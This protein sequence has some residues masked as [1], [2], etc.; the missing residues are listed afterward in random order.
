[1]FDNKKLIGSSRLFANFIFAGSV[2]LLP[3]TNAFAAPTIGLSTSFLPADGAR[4]YMDIGGTWDGTQE[5]SNGDGFTLSVA[6]TG[7]DPAFD[8]RDIPVTVPTG[9]VLASN[10]VTVTD[11]G[12][13]CP[14]M[15]ANASQAGSGNPVTINIFSNN[16]TVINP[17]CTYNYTFRLETNTTAPAGTQSIGYTVTYNTINN[18]NSSVASTLGTQNINVNAGGISVT[19]STAITSAVTGQVISYNLTV[20]STGNG[21]LFDVEL[22]DVLSSDLNNLTFNVPNPPPGANGPGADDYTFEYLSA[23]EI[24]NLTVDATVSP[25]L[26]CPL[27][28][29]TANMSER[30]GIATDSAGPVNV[31]YDFQFTSGSFSNVLSHAAT[32]YCEFC[33]DGT[34]T[35]T[36]QN[37]SNAPLTNVSLL[38]D[39]KASGLVYITG[40][41]TFNGGGVADP[42]IT[43]GSNQ[44]LTWALP[45]IAGSGSVVVS[46]GVR[47]ANAEALNTAVRDIIATVD[48]DMSCLTATQSVNSGDFEVPIRQPLPNIFKDGRNFDAGQSG[49]TD[50]IFGSFNDDIIWRVNVQNAGLANMQAL[51]MNDATNGPP[52]DNF[53]INYICPTEANAVAITNNNGVDPGTSCIAMG[54]PF[55]VADPFG[56]APD[57]DDIALSSNNAFIYYV[58]RIKNL[59]TTITNTA[60]ISWGCAVNS[61][62][63]GNIT[64]PASSNGITPGVGI[65]ETGILN[66][67]VS[68]PGLQ[69]TQTVT[70]SNASQPLGAKGLIT[71]TLNNQTD[72]SIQKITVD[73]DLP[74]GYVMDESYGVVN[75]VGIGQPT[76]V[77]NPAYGTTYPGF[78]DTFTRDDPQLNN[79]DPLDDLNPT[80]TLSSSTT[81][82]NAAQQV[83][84]LRNGDVVSFTFGIIMIDPNAFD[85][86]SDLD[87]APE[88]IAD[89]TDP[90][91]A[92]TNL[93]NNV[94][95]N[96]DSVDPSGLQAQTRNVN[97]TYD[98]D[99]ED[100][101]VS[102]SDALFILTNNPGTPLALNVD[103]TNN[104][105]H[106]ADDYSLY[107]SLGQAMVV[108]TP[109]AGCSLTS[110]APP[111]PTWN[112][113]SAIPGPLTAPVT[114]AAEIYLCNRGTIAPGQTQTFTFDV[115]KQL[116]GTPA[117]DL[118]FRADVVGEVRLFDTTRLTYSGTPASP[119][120]TPPSLPET[121]P[122]Q[123]LANNYTLDAI[124]SRVLGFNLTKSVLACSESAG[125]E[126]QIGEDCSYHIES[127]GWFGF[128]T[129]G[130]TLIAVENVVVTD[131]LPNN[132]GLDGQ[133][134]I[135]FPG[136]TSPYYVFNNTPKI[137]M[138]GNGGATTTPLDA[139]DITWSF[140][141]SGS[142]IV[143]KDEFFRVDLKTRLLNNPVDLAYPVPG[144]YAPNL[145]GNITTNIARTSFDAIFNSASGNVTI[146]VDD[147]VGIPGYPVPAVRTVN[148]TEVEPNLIVTKQV[149]N[150]SLNGSGTAC[151][152]FADAIN[153]GDTNDSYIYRITLT[154]ENSVPVRSPAFNVIATDTLDASDLMFVM[155]FANDNL[156]NNGDGS[157]ANGD[158]DE[159][160]MYAAIPDNTVGNGIP[161]VITVDESFGAPFVQVDPGVTVTFYYRVD[162]DITIAPLQTLTNTVSMSFD[163]LDGDFG[164]QNV[165]QYNNSTAPPNDIG[166]AR[167]YTSIAQI[168]DV[169]M[170]PVI[171][172]PK[173][174]VTT[175][176]TPPSSPQNVSVGEEVRYLLV[177]DLPV[178]NLRQFKIRDEL[179]AGIRCIEGLVVNL[180]AP[181]YKAAGFVPGGTFVSNCT[182]TGTNDFVEWNFGNQIVTAAGGPGTRFNFP[183]SFIARVENSAITTGTTVI[184]NGGGTVNTT[185]PPSASYCTGGVGVCYVNDV[186]TV[187]PHNF[188][189]VDIVVR[190]PVIALTKSFLPVTNSDA[191]DVLTVTVTAENTG[192]SVAYNLQVLDDLVGSDMTYKPGSLGGANPPDNVDLVTLGANQPIFSWD[193]A[194]PDYAIQTGAA[195]LK[196][197]TFQV[198][199]DTTAQPLELLDNTLQSKWDS[200]PDQNTA[201]PHNTA[202]PGI[203]P[204][205]SILGLRNG[206]VP[207]LATAPN[208]YETIAAASTTVPPLTMTKTD[209]VPAVIP[210]IG[211]H[212]N[213]QVVIELPEGTTENLIVDDELVFGGVSYALSR[214]ASFDITYT[215][216]DIVSINGLAPSEAAFRGATAG[217]PTLPVDNDTGTITW[218]IGQIITDEED[219]LDI[220]PN[221]V[222]PRIIINYFAR[223]NNDA[224]TIDGVSIQNSATVN[225]DHG[226]GGAA[227]SINDRTAV[228]TVVEP[229]LAITKAVSNITNLGVGPVAGDVLE[230]QISINN[231]GNSTAF[232]SN[233]TDTLDANLLFDASFTPT[234]LLNTVAVSGFVSTPSGVPGGPLIWGR[235]N[236]DNSLDIPV[237]PG[238]T[239]VLT[240]RVIVQNTIEANFVISNSALVDWTSLNDTDPSNPFERTGA[241]CPL[242]S[243][244]NT[245]CSAPAVADITADNSNNI[246]KTVIDDTWPASPV[247]TLRVGDVVTYQLGVNIQQG[248][249]VSMRIL[250]AIDPGMEFV[251]VVSINGAVAAPYAPPA[252]GAGSNFSYV[253]IPAGDVPA[254]GDAPIFNWDLGTII[255][256]FS[257]DTTTDMLVII[258]RARVV[259]NVA[260]TIPQQPTTQINNTANLTFMD[261]NNSPVSG[262]SGSAFIT[263]LQPVMDNLTKTDRSGRVSGGPITP[264]ID[265][266]N[267]TLHSCNTTGLA[268]A[269]GLLLTD[270]LPTQLNET[271]ITGPTN[272]ALAPDVL[273]NGVLAVAAT[274]YVYTPP[275]GPGG[276]MV[277]R[278]NT[279]IDPGVCIDINFDV[280]FYT[281]FGFGAF[282]ND[283][284]VNEYYSLP[285]ADAQLYGPLGPA[286]FVMNNPLAPIPAPVKVK[287]SADEATIGDEVIYQITVPSVATGAV[288]YDVTTTDVLDSSLILVSAVDTG[289]SNF[290]ITTT[291]LAGNTISMV[292]DQIPAGQTAIIELRARVDNN[293]AANASVNFNNSASYTYANSPG[294]LAINAGSDITVNALSIVEPLVAVVK[295]VTNTTKAGAPDAGDILRYTV[296]LSAS[297]GA[298]APA[299]FF[300]D[301]FD[302]SIDD[303]LSLGLLYIDGSETVNGGNSINLPVKV[304]DG[305][306]TPQTLSWSPANP[307]PSDIDVAEG[308]TV[309]VTY[310]VLVLDSVLANQNLSNSVDIQWS[311]RDG[312]D[313]NERDGSGLPLNDYFN[314]IT[315]ST[316]EITPDNNVITKLKLS[317]TFNPADNIVRI[318]DIVEYELRINMQEGSNP[319]FVVQ[320]NLPRGL[321]FEQTV[322]INGQT[323]APYADVAPF[324]YA[325][326]P[327]AV[328]VGDP[329]TGPT[330]VSWSTADVINA[331]DNITTNNDFVIIYRARVLNLA[332]PQINNTPLNNIVDF[333]YTT[334]SGPAPTKTDNQQLDLQQPD[335][336]VTKTSV[337]AAGSIIGANDFVTY[338]VEIL[339]SGASI[340]YDTELLDTIPFGLRSPAVN[341]ISII[342]QPSGVVLPNL[343]PVYNPATGTASWNF[344]TGT[345]NQYNIPAGQR[346]QI[347]YQMQADAGLGAGLNMTN[348][349]QV[350]LYYSF[351]DDATPSVPPITGVREIYGP[352]NIASVTLSTVLPNALLKVNPAD[353]NI[354]IGETFNYRITIPETPQTTTLYDVQILDDLNLS[355]ADLMF[356][357]ATKVSGSL[358]FT[359]VNIGTVSGELIIADT[360]N[361]IDVPANEQVVID[362]TVTLRDSATN[363]ASLP[364]TNAAS[365]T[366]NQINGD[367]A[368]VSTGLGNTTPLMTIVE[369]DLTMRKDGPV[370]TVNFLA[371][372][373]YTV[374]VENIGTGPAFDTTITDRLPNVPDNPPLTGGTC[375]TTP[376]NFVAGITTS[377]D[378]SIVIRA[379]T[380]GTDYNIAYTAAP[381]CELLITTITDAAR[382]ESNE[383]LIVSYDVTLNVASQSGA[384][385]TNIAGATEWFSLNTAG[386]GATGE[387]RTYSEILTDGTPAITDFQDAFTV[388]VEAPVL[389]VQK[390]V[391]NV[392]SGQNPGNNAIPGE[393]L[394]YTIV[395]N[396]T[397]IVDANNMTLSDALPANTTYVANSTTLNTLAVPDAGAGISPLIGG[398]DISSSNLTPPLPIAGTGVISAGQLAT[399][400]F[401]VLLNPVITSGTV[402]LNQAIA[403]SPSTGPLPSDDPNVAG[404]ADPTPTL[405]TSAPVFLVQKTSLDITGD[406]ALLMP[407]DTLRYTLTVKNIGQENAVNSLLSDQIPANTSYVANSTRLN[408][409][410]VADPA[411]GISPL[412][413]SM[414]INAPENTTP[415]FLRA[416]TN[417]VADNVATITFDVVVNPAAITGTIISNQ[418]FLS[419][420]GAGSGAFPLQ[421]SDDPNT[422]LVDD[423]TI[424]VV[425]N[426]PV[427]SVLKTVAIEDDVIGNNRLDPGDTIRY[428]ITTTNLGGVAA[429]D[430]VL[431]DAVPVNTTYVANSTKLNTLAVADASGGTSPLI[432]GIAISSSDLTPPLPTTGNG[433]LSPANS[434]VVTFDVVVNAA[435]PVGT[436]ISNQGFVDTNETPVEPSD[437][438]GNSANGNQPTLIVVGNV[439]QLAITKQV[440]VVGGGAA[441][442][443][444]ELEYVVRVT[445]IGGITATS[446]V[447]ND[448]MS[449]PVAGQKTYVVGSGRLDGLPAGISFAGTVLTATVG[450]LAPAAVAEL[451]F[452]VLLSN[453]LSIG[454]S[455]INTGDVSW[456][457]PAST[458][459]ASVSID[460]GGTPGSVNIN[461]QVWDD[462]DFSNDVSNGETLLQDYRVELYRNGSLLANTLTD[463]NGAFAFNGL[464]PNLPSDPYELRFIAPGAIATTA[465]LGTTNSAFIDGSQRISGIF[466]ASGTNVQNLNLPRQAN[467]VVYDSVLRVPVAGVGLSM[468]NL[469]RSNQAVPGSCFDDPV[470]ANQVTLANGLYKFNLNFSDSGRCAQGDEY[471][472]QVQPPA[473]DFTGTT[474]V[475]IP[476]VSSSP[477]NV[478]NCPGTSADKIPAT[479][480]HCEN[481]TSSSQPA[482]TVAPRTSGTEYYLTFL[483][484]DQ[485]FTDQIYNNHIA[486]DGV[487]DAAVAISKV[488][489]KLNVTRSDLVPYTITFKN[490]LGVPLFDVSIIDNFPAGFK[491]VKG[492]ARVDGVEIEPQID[493]RML[494]WSG[495]NVDLNESRIIKLLL[496]VGS[497]V[498]EGK[499][500]NSAQAINTITGSDVSGV[501]TATVRVI[502]DPT[503]DCTDII[504]KVYNDI[505][506]NGYQDQGE[507]GVA[508]AQVA[509]AR[510]LRVTTDAHGR[511]HIT[512]AIVPNEVRG[513]NFIMKLDEHSLPSGYRVTTEN[514]RVQ[515]ATRGKMIKF[516]FGT[517]VHRVVKLDLAD[518]VFEKG[519]TELRPQ[520]RSRIGLLI[521]EL[522]KQGSILRLSYLAEN[523]TEDEVDDRLDAIE[524]LISDRW[525]DLD[526]CYRLDIETEVFWRRGG[527]PVGMEFKE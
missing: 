38:E 441:L 11:V 253:P 409:V 499:Y 411:A 271:T 189:P 343:A 33:G 124:R 59:H 241:G 254:A 435:T 182:S 463:A 184:T 109:A 306:V 257:G 21:G 132:L 106:D 215:F 338:T 400:T 164:N 510:G 464:P 301:A 93:T 148:Q 416:D 15:S 168:A 277:F 77:T 500:V 516:N 366:F 395:V 6:N 288:L 291:V 428:T 440:S 52:N 107:V 180:D 163:S 519:K 342:L 526:C 217:P 121:S 436:I 485:P 316:N 167:I 328:V 142:G 114:P 386:A 32:S 415:G 197:F 345:A 413:T 113:P 472:I 1:L 451:R 493:G 424:D 229:V 101:D 481:S 89:G 346:L 16:S 339:N 108:Q 298:A 221:I 297:G 445:N 305:V 172:L 419:G 183:I 270:N 90:D 127:G 9:F 421:P 53:D 396:N 40:T 25:V 234:A 383:K 67:T 460:I 239:L 319:N 425:G 314:L 461:G 354:S 143:V 315:A 56:N 153:N 486:V 471:R 299:D 336:S 372:L 300:S 5:V 276:D 34:I 250:D 104:G 55:N 399:I 122:N 224:A 459:S 79:G 160:A 105:G 233:I 356:V 430:A 433:V 110:N 62:T 218:D 494:T 327:A 418:G 514:P 367:N 452:R 82:A 116:S 296:T 260:T 64:V 120:L 406:P 155:D 193:I 365:Y 304:G 295:T 266:M 237:G 525:E 303:T 368:S 243:G 482:P 332:L 35:L 527:P 240:Y 280:A 97:F 503:F 308:T 329:A 311:S 212:R 341:V 273:I 401:D 194:N 51:K 285:P 497:G 78:I 181:P 235:G 207:N 289:P 429:T 469:T 444:S 506:L 37:P 186:G 171:A 248:T 450:N 72:G 161:A 402:I 403:D 426:V 374:V 188:A 232:D 284:L 431:T 259:D 176:N 137:N 281:N 381:T 50:P 211:A 150:E 492:S 179:P 522:Q 359:P 100:L 98:S 335:L 214:N 438:D 293:A 204:D 456:D 331:G 57:P 348:A 65:I 501:A 81:G 39:L 477:E 20:T 302:L 238:Q 391:L 457:T 351:D 46:F 141:A 83:D 177:A 199:V 223:A 398:I 41:T 488:S 138:I 73:T 48:F 12:G 85:L 231:T 447:I 252:T 518:G 322:S 30:R 152:I 201:L 414:L 352:S 278:F 282:S 156:D 19:K 157:S 220:N 390:T 99:P 453:T 126:M 196:T 69:I 61:P 307:V 216:E 407:G 149:C 437:A 378:E 190:E 375:D 95:V 205:G 18:D 131:D 442:A 263:I 333:D 340:A 449:L 256:D 465:S 134:F 380:Q 364:F 310:D 513:S 247:G 384:A 60:D 388:I 103:L 133:G 66:T 129:P 475:I 87:V 71:I 434:A 272:G 128:I 86:V 147:A 29:N 119:N 330:T 478:P 140:N 489:S 294:G 2:F 355:A 470:Q 222:N 230:Y 225:Y 448:D 344:D 258:Y 191:A 136:S 467:G 236:A 75:G 410:I 323:I 309:T 479:A 446:V 43:G 135:P 312:P 320:D 13:G 165:P 443:G 209:L 362:I 22:N 353:T 251:D 313:V 200:L 24:V 210:T 498:G 523:E 462:P 185:P 379:L 377:L 491:Y 326:I 166:R 495:L 146:N 382:V 387:I 325:A 187:V 432:A 371:P 454:D 504:G 219:D 473:D 412:A 203:G 162:P 242:V 76:S 178:A 275:A 123:Q 145:H 468:V 292:I 4:T 68:P 262:L 337:P 321:I 484:N 274:D 397:G 74:A 480:Q 394:R 264:G 80:F 26:A 509:T 358:P 173:L 58:G 405:I 458:L 14:N 324:T 202:P 94:V 96:F 47:S 36:V 139:N 507:E 54:T 370:G 8:I 84:M 246:V 245:Y 496:I 117:D 195:N 512:C 517:A 227:P 206:A 111:H 373:P 363:V 192:T 439:Q 360:T 158:P 112:L 286:I 125:F 521:N 350:Q 261:G 283:I 174:T 115:I 393:V 144:G 502:P 361:G 404:V 226:N 159:I 422:A 427:V 44:L 169:T 31:Q 505:N 511:F 49:Y 369:P 524:E 420:A 154:N 520:W 42:A 490:T 208:L 334:A 92:I 483:F 265:V 318:G 515:R 91:N 487:L 279:P 255:N 317:D 287:L 347:V 213:F 392:T 175:S 474:S 466:A 244:T 268:P 417:V 28:N 17:G 27:L 198:V 7:P 10:A 508:G 63:G 357:S 267:F 269:Y 45:N 102:I 376:V 349:A 389:D 228:Q 151:S 23:G 130:F 408:A 290:P 249:S 170:I 88:N 118:T 423:P 70:G 385:L 476:P 455:V 3:I